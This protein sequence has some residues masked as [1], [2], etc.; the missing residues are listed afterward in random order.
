MTS[1][2]VPSTPF[3]LVAL[4]ILLPNAA[5]AQS[6]C[7]DCF[8]PGGGCSACCWEDQIPSCPLFP[9]GS[10]G[11]YCLSGGPGGG[12]GCGGL[13]LSSRTLAI[14]SDLGFE[15]ASYQ[16]RFDLSKGGERREGSFI[17]EEWALVSSA[18]DETAVLSAS[19]DA[20]RTRVQVVAERFQ[21]SG[22]DA[23]T[24]LVI[25]DAEHPHNSREIPAPE[26][27]PLEFDAGLPASAAGQEAWFRAEIG[28]DGVIDQVIVLNRP[29][30]FASTSI[31]EGLRKHLSLRYAD[32]ER[33]RVVVF[34]L[35]RAD[36]TGRLTM[37]THRLVFPTCCCGGVR[38]V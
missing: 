3:L 12:G 25:E 33:H 18:G 2:R 8:Y 14:G 27:A 23:S 35:V 38:C 20:F 15:L 36:A 17:F 1:R 30:G 5:A 26:V 21:P 24:V 7:C 11:C 28:E 22:G 4:A 37:T 9:D 10:C 19:S 16:L 6:N 13:T 31:H 34:G 32:K 29:A